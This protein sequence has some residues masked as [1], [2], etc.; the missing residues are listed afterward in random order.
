MEEE[1]MSKRGRKRRSRKGNGA[2]HGK[3][4]NA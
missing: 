2:N 3:R 1:L 4:P